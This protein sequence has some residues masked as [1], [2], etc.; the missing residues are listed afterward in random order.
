MIIGDTTAPALAK[1]S[2]AFS[3]KV[4]SESD[5]WKRI[6][7]KRPDQ[8]SETL[9]A[10]K[11]GENRYQLANAPIFYDD[12]FLGDIVA[13]KP[14]ETNP[15][16]LLFEEVVEEGDNLAM[17]M[18]GP[19]H[20]PEM[21]R[22]LKTLSAFGIGVEQWGGFLAVLSMPPTVALPDSKT[23]FGMKQPP[24][25]LTAPPGPWVQEVVG[26]MMTGDKEAATELIYAKSQ[27]FYAHYGGCDEDDIK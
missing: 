5:Y 22:G 23:V 14:D 17:V 21:Q 9:W 6:T 19:F 8:H 18:F 11:V 24:I 20:L 15:D 13:A 27:E 3:A 7:F 16:I 26:K 12:A 10:T 25:I 4:N 1:Y 2:R